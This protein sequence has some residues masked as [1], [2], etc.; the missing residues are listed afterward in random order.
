MWTIIYLLQFLITPTAQ[1]AKFECGMP[2]KPYKLDPK[3]GH[4]DPVIPGTWSSV[5]NICFS[6]L[7]FVRHVGAHLYLF[8]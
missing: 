6:G 8:K 1:H 3:I 2:W 5:V 4:I 7:F